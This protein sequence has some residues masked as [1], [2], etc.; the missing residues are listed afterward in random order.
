MTWKLTLSELAQATHGQI[1][2]THLTEFIGVGTDTRLDL[3][4]QVFFALKGDA[5]D[6]H[7]FLQQAVAKNAAVLVVHSKNAALE[8]LSK[9]VSVLLV[10][11]TLKALQNLGQ[12]W[13]KKMSAKILA[14]TGTNGKTTTK[15]F[16][17]AILSS[18]LKVQYSKGSFNNHWGV[19]LSLLS[20]HP[21]HQVAVIEMGM[22][23]P[24]EIRDLVAIAKPNVVAVTMVGRGHLQGLQSIDGVA[25]AKEEIYRCSDSGIEHIYN[26]DNPHTFQMFLRARSL[27][28]RKDATAPKKI[29]SFS[30]QTKTASE[31]G[32]DVRLEVISASETSLTVTGEIHGVKNQVVIPV[33]GAH[34]ITNLMLA[35]CFALSAGFS[36]EEIWPALNRCQNAWGRNQWV[37]TESGAKILFDAYNANPESMRAAIENFS[38]LQTSAKK[39]VL[40]GEMR[41][42]GEASSECHYELGKNVGA[43][44]F[45][46]IGFVGPSHSDFERGLRESGFHGRFEHA[47]SYEV[48][49]LQKWWPILHADET[50]LIK[51]SRGV[52]LERALQECKPTNFKTK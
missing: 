51:G 44:D 37:D 1:L 4:G 50:M 39:M 15:E 29:M 38:A 35:C 43:Q 5:F 49:L 14:V 19:P 33:F 32:C 16:T 23:H 24:G 8:A 34:N 30:S 3:S 21:E 7:E 13:R 9:N 46:W 45:Y 42:L 25:A 18:K 36:A 20:I 10:S 41:E 28:E 47:D 48:G 40:L 6:A 22:N 31:F 17:A 11:D 27:V 52:G 12:Y 2:S 26:L